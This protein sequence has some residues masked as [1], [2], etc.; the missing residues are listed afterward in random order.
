MSVAMSSR[1]KHRLVATSGADPD[2][3][4]GMRDAQCSQFSQ[5]RQ[6]FQTSS[7][8]PVT[9]V[10]GAAT[11]FERAGSTPHILNTATCMIEQH[12]GTGLAEGSM[13]S[14]SLLEQL[15]N[16]RMSLPG[17]TGLDSLM[18]HPR[19]VALFQAHCLQPEEDVE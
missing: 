2:V 18:L 17:G 16:D 11:A 19:F 5:Q 9:D 8:W 14:M 7:T 4:E 15:S 10:M 12:M 13:S 1:V 3:H 6:A